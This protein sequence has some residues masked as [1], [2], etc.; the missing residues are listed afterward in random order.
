MPRAEDLLSVVKPPGQTKW[1]QPESVGIKPSQPY[2][3]QREACRSATQEE[4]L[5]FTISSTVSLYF[6]R[7]LWPYSGNGTAP[8]QITLKGYILKISFCLS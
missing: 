2:T 1:A 6:I 8:L 4:G 7:Y 5:P 3:P